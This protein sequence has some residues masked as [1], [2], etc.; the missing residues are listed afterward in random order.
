MMRVL[1]ISMRLL[2]SGNKDL[3][4]IAGQ[5]FFEKIPACCV[6]DKANIFSACVPA[7]NLGI[8]PIQS[9]NIVLPRCCAQRGSGIL[10]LCVWQQQLLAR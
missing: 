8:R 3:H 5:N 9:V 7:A 6:W 4:L 2:I 1:P 10:F